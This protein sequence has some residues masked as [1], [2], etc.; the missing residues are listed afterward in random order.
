M[1]AV[2]K[3]T[4]SAPASFKTAAAASTVLPV[5]KISSTSRTLLNFTSYG[6]ILKAFFKFF[7][8]LFRSSSFCSEVSSFFFRRSGMTGIFKASPSGTARSSAWLKPRQRL[9]FG[10]S[11]IGAMTSIS[12]CSSSSFRT[13]VMAAEK[14]SA[15]LLLLRSFIFKMLF[16][17]FPV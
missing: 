6:P 10:C 16:L 13:A 15:F 17:I 14:K 1:Q 9:F 4:A 7:W 12:Q 11:G 5:V 3:N 2:R 8:R